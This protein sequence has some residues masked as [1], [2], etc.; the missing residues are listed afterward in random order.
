MKLYLRVLAFSA[1]LFSLTSC[2]KDDDGPSLPTYEVPASYTFDNVNFEASAD[3]VKMLDNINKYL[4]TAQSSMDRVTLDQTKLNNMWLNTGNAFDT[5]GLNDSDVNLSEITSDPAT[6]KGYIDAMVA[7][8]NENLTPAAEGSAGYIARNA[9]KILV[10]G[11]GL[12]YVQAV[13]KGL[14]GAALFNEGI[15][16]LQL[17]PLS[18]NITVV[19]GEGTAMAHNFDL[20]Y[21]YFSLPTNY[22]TSAEFATANRSKL[23]FWG[24]Y[25]RERGLY[26]NAADKIWGAFR[27]G[28]AAIEA[29]DLATVTQQ[30]EII[31]EYWEKVAA[32]AAW[33]YIT[34][35]QG[36]TGNLASQFHALSEGF[37]FVA[38]LK[39]RPA[40]SP[41]TGAQYDQLVD[42]L[43][44]D[45]NFYDL[46]NDPSFTSLNA[47]KAILSTAYG[48]L[49]AD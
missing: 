2:D 38:A 14:M 35:P 19:P 44:P 45:A 29:K 20:A 33:A 43:G 7:L 18:E 9:G 21:G 3:R 17:V 34:I 23:L 30:V 27:T 28:R 1:V 12:E 48:Q 42:I 10:S 26:I 41:L 36:Q 40:N 37:G 13:Q 47:A 32:A 46:V 39:Y 5:A 11:N 31:K 4:G 22:D 49:Q 25:L 6:F 15:R 24:N 8:S 16:L